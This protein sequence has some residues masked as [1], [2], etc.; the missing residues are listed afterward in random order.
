M[1]YTLAGAA[2]TSASLP[3][4]ATQRLERPGLGYLSERS[5]GRHE[6]GRLSDLSD[7]GSA[8]GRHEN[9]RWRA[10]AT[11]VHWRACGKRASWP[12]TEQAASEQAASEQAASEQAASEQAASEQAASEQAMLPDERRRAGEAR[13][14]APRRAET[15]AA[16]AQGDIRSC[17]ALRS[18]VRAQRR[19]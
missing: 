1:A 10:W 7:P 9:V 14:S 15:G 19:G 8:T 17:C 18:S 13:H 12:A 2:R 16:L 11:R 6:R 4:R 3:T 5:G